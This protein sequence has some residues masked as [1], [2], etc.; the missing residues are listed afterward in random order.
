MLAGNLLTSEVE[1]MR[2]LSQGCNVLVVEDHVESA[3]V[4]ARLLRMCGHQVKMAHTAKDAQDLAVKEH[5]DVLICD[6]EL[7]DGNGCEVF[8]AVNATYRVQGIALTG[9]DAP[10]ILASC[11][12]AGFRAHLTKPVMFE[13]IKAAFDQLCSDD[14]THEA[15]QLLPAR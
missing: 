4:L 13:S 5:F 15:K 3:D 2:T 12:Q 10:E 1:P 9:H 14:F 11:K 7:P 6:I 8:Q